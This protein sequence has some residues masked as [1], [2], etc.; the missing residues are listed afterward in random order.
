[1]DSKARNDFAMAVKAALPRAI[2]VLAAAVAGS[3]I[4]L[5]SSSRVLAEGLY[6]DDAFYY[7][8]IA[9][10]LVNGHG[11]T[12]DTFNPTNGFQVLWLLLLLPVAAVIT[13]PDT[14]VAVVWWMQVLLGGVAA[15]LTFILADSLGPK[16]R[17]WIPSAI[18]ISALPFL[19]LWN[20]GMV[21]GLETPA[22]TVAL[23]GSLLLLQNFRVAPSTKSSWLLTTGLTLTI[24]GRLDGLLFVVLT[25]VAI[26]LWKSGTLR[27]RIQV[28]ALP[29][30][31]SAVY[32]AANLMFFGSLSPV[33]GATKTIWGER[34]LDAAIS[35]GTPEWQL[36]LSNIAWPKQ[37][38][39][40]LTSRLPNG[41]GEWL[42]ID[43]VVIL[44]VLTAYGVIVWFYWRRAIP[45]LAIFQ[46]FLMG[47][48]LVY[49]YLQY[50]FANYT[51]YWTLD[52]IGIVLF[53]AILTQGL[54]L[55][56]HAATTAT[57][58]AVLVGFLTFALI[59]NSLIERGRAWLAPDPTTNEIAEYAG[60]KYAAET[61]NDSPLTRNLLMTSSDAGIL[62]FYL[63]GPLVNMDGLVNGRQR[64]DFTK[65]YGMDQ[66][67]YLLAHP[68][69]DG[70]VNWIPTNANEGTLERMG[71]A[72][73][74]EVPTFAECV[75]ETHGAVS[76]DRG[77]IRLFLRPEQAAGWDCPARR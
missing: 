17:I 8:E 48:F 63:Q 70:F 71:R 74:V 57:A 43:A 19:P 65:R 38:L 10:N 1:M 51:W 67:P 35:A 64:L 47:K 53:V 4:A 14:F 55:R 36:R 26:W 58:S 27:Q 77:Q 18:V 13:D 28:V 11:L 66:L 54:L 9:A 46:I 32:F 15:S 52:L 44:A 49:G 75:A 3:M 72:G 2:I 68:E 42:A 59:G 56:R 45:V 34:K 30:V 20:G 40:P 21:N 22:F 69:F 29:I 33:S 76:N 39:D 60:S 73:F 24:L 31:V 6:A 41:L 61:L 5:P 62:G 7:F 37:Y 23:L 50:G 16:S 12:F 25:G